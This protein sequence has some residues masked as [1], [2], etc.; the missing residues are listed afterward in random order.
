MWAPAARALRRPLV[1]ADD[2]ELDDG[3]ERMNLVDSTLTANAYDVIS[4]SFS[5]L[6]DTSCDSSARL[7]RINGGVGYLV[8]EPWGVCANDRDTGKPKGDPPCIAHCSESSSA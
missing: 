6:T 7:A 5:K 1:E 3:H 4:G 8:G 2:A